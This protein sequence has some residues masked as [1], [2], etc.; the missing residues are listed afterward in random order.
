LENKEVNGVFN[1]GTG[2]PR[3]W[4]DLARA[5]FTAMGRE[6]RIEYI[7]MPESLRPKYQYYTRAQTE[8]LQ[9]VG[10]PLNF[11]SLEDG[12]RD[13]VQNYLAAPDP[14]LDSSRS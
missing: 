5:V 9:A 7:Q 4:N 3:T 11:T 6:P 13:Y 1:L 10:C 12:A 2:T 8:K 14:Y